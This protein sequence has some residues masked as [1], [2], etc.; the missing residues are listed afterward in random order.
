MFL[1]TAAN[2]AVTFSVNS[3]NDSLP[4]VLGLLDNAPSGLQ[5]LGKSDDAVVPFTITGDGTQSGTWSYAGFDV[6]AVAIKAGPDFLL[7]DYTNDGPVSSDNWCT[8]ASCSISGTTA[9][10]IPPLPS[11]I[12]GDGSNPNLSHL[13]LYGIETTTPSIPEPATWLMM[14]IGFGLTGLSLKRRRMVA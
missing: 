14:I 1:Q 4:V 7:V 6:Y 12:V 10:S 2:A 5:L 9:S 11:L 3:G 13:S 8:D